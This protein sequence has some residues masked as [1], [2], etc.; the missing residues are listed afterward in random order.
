MPVDVEALKAKYG[1]LSQLE[2]A[3]ETFI[4]RSPTRDVWKRFR[5][6]VMDEGKRTVA[7][8]NLVRGCVVSPEMTEFEA[9]VDRLPGIVETLGKTLVEMAGAGGEA[10]KKAL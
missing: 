8:D 7:M 2:A 10:E 4:V 5:A 1:P 3:G 6:Q 9:V